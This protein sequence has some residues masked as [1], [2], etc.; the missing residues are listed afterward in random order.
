MQIA[1]HIARGDRQAAIAAAVQYLDV[2]QTDTVVWEQL[3]RL[4]L[5]AGQLG[6]AQF[7]LEEALLA[8]PNNVVTLLKLADVL[9]AQGGTLVQAAR[10]YY[11]RVVELTKGENARALYGIVACNAVGAGPLKVDGAEEVAAG[12]AELQE[13][14]EQRLRRMYAASAPELLPCVEA[15]LAAMQPK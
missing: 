7:C 14:A 2:F 15:C 13:L 1:I 12:D 11:A 4:Y 6:Q 10:G 5:D 8:A 3:A 9:F